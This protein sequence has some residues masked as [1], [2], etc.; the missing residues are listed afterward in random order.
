MSGPAASA[1]RPAEPRAA[2]AV[3]ELRR[4]VAAAHAAGG[5]GVATTRLMAELCDGIVRDVWEEVCGS[6]PQT[7]AGGMAVVAVGGYGRREMAPH[8]DVDLMVLHDGSAGAAEPVAEAARRLLQDLFDAGLQVGQSVRTAAQA[9]R[10]AAEDATIA[11]SLLDLRPVAGDRGLA[12]RL[13]ARL[14]AAVRR[15]P[16]R[17]AAQLVAARRA[18][19][20]K[21]GQTVSLLEPNVKRSPG[22]LRDIQLVHWLGIV[23]HAADTLDDLV[24]A[25]GLSA[26]D[27]AATAAAAD[28]LWRV[29][30][31]LHLGAGRCADDLTREEQARIAAARGIESTAGLLG[32]E[33]FMREYFGHTRRVAQVV[34]SLA[35]GL[36]RP[37]PLRRAAAGILGQR[38]D[39]RFRVGPQDVAALPGYR[40]RVAGGADTILRLVELAQ[41]HG[42]PIEPATWEEVRNRSADLRDDP[43]PAATAAFLRLFDRPDG[44]ADALRR[45]LDAGL[46]ERFVPPFAHARNLL[47]FNNYHKYTVDEHSIL[48]VERAAAL[49]RD[50]G[51]LGAAWRELGR[52]RPLLLA[53]LVHDLGKGFPEDHSELGAR[54]ARDVAVRLGLGSDEGEIVEFL[55]L[56][57]L[58]MAHLAFR[59]DTGDDS[60]VVRFAS[61][62][63]SPEMLRMLALLTAADVAAVGP[64]TWTKWKADLLG[65]LYARA[66]G[67][68]DGTSPSAA[69]DRTRRELDALVSGRDPDD[70]VARLAA[71]LP[72]SYLRDTASPR[73]V[74]ELGRVARLPPDGVFAFARWQPETST[75]AVTVGTRED[76]APG[77][78][79]R[80]TA[81]L[82]AERLQVLAAG[83]HTLEEGIVLDHFTALDP[84]F[85]GEPP[86]SR[87]AEIAAAIRAA[88]KAERP[89]AV[90]RVWNP[91]APRPAAAA[92]VRVRFDNESSAQDTIVEV[93]ATDAPGLLSGVARAIFE[94]GLSVRSARIGTH[95]DQVV[96]AFHVVDATGGKLTDPG[97]LA[98]LRQAIEAAAGPVTGPGG[99]RAS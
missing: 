19:A 21:Y 98:A 5:A 87:L 66:L 61:D 2:A 80:V 29:R 71:R 58:A 73:I 99:G 6:L 25:G 54:L 3:R 57:H 85:A 88:V 42:L 93:F 76:V 97:R 10:L 39:G 15:A 48:T 27:A 94:A 56:K 68:L 14:S 63:G 1:D 86:A 60:L 36:H 16:R 44:L 55:V 62:V 31:D 77:I 69:A 12:E 70:P 52:H 30:V 89:P 43:G 9:C 47:Q 26:A 51:W 45:L 49:G 74:E 8:S 18:E 35:H 23:L 50:D 91:F 81:A 22:G 79:H 7:A 32:V 13:A 72:V 17:F 38:V 46:L 95:L 64:G 90:A 11:S 65:E 40:D 78:F 4:T 20:D 33:V 82:A 83:I 75:V 34:E 84:D 67:H 41:R 24:A 37:G 92:P 53:C 96:D 59:R 28:F